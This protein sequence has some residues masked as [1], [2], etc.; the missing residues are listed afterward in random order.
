VRDDDGSKFLV[1]ILPRGVRTAFA[2]DPVY[3]SANLI[4]AS[5][6]IFFLRASRLPFYVTTPRLA[7][8]TVTNKRRNG[9]RKNYDATFSICFKKV[10]KKSLTNRCLE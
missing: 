5:L 2:I 9:W 1:E 7:V 6:T 4:V 10:S 8:A 3:R